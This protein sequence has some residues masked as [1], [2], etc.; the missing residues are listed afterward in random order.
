MEK[1]L[2]Q[3]V[4]RHCGAVQDELK[5]VIKWW[6]ELKGYMMRLSHTKCG[7][8][9]VTD[10]VDQCKGVRQ[11]CNLSPCIFNIFITVTKHY[12]HA[13]VIRKIA[14]PG[15]LFIYLVHPVVFMTS[16]TSVIMYIKLQYFKALNFNYTVSNSSIDTY[17]S[18]IVDKEQCIEANMY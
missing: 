12:L 17:Y 1:C 6:C 7:A 5:E 18:S 15:F 11:G 10:F 13:H 8:D 2:T 9:E 3:S 4:G 16:D 14:V